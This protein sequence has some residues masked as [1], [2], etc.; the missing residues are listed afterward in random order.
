MGTSVERELTPQEQARMPDARHEMARTGMMG[1]ATRFTFFA[2]FD[3]TNNHKDRLE[4]SGLP[5]QTNV[6][7]L[8]DQADSS[9]DDLLETGYYPGVGT[10]GDQGGLLQAGVFPT[11]AIESAADK[12]YGEFADAAVAYLKTQPGA[13]VADLGTAVTGFSRGAATA[14]RFAQLVHER[15][16][17]GPGGEVVA[18]P[19]RIPVT[20]MALIDPVARFVDMPMDIPP[21]VRGQVL[22]VIAEHE[23]RSDFRPLHYMNDPRVSHVDHPGNHVGVGGG[24]D[25]HGTGASVL[26]GVTAYF[27]R[28]GV[29][30]DKVPPQRQHMPAA[31]QRLYSEVWRT[32]RNGDV[33]READ[34]RRQ[35]GWAHDRPDQGRVGVLPQVS[36]QHMA[37]L[38]Q[39]YAAIAPALK[40]QGLDDARSLQVA[41]ACVRSV[42][43]WERLLGEPRRY[44]VSKDGQSVAICHEVNVLREVSVPQALE[45]SCRDHLAAANAMRE[46]QAQQAPQP[47]EWSVPQPAHEHSRRQ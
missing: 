42:A 7:N 12:A 28:R 17:V 39:S 31:P 13:T 44:L 34:G 5:W 21:N 11:R 24:Y 47:P 32:A 40:A 3:G 1:C 37:W 26:E 41:A 45:T 8:F 29:G 6:G 27:Q 16:L 46:L 15:G 20:A 33:L 25:A 35:A 14:I 18:P 22:A 30:I 38:R 9:Q 19:G 43:R 10:G 4:L 36:R 2:A 23:Q